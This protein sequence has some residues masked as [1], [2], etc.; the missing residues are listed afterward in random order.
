MR[1]G[2]AASPLIA[3][4]LPD[5]IV[6]LMGVPV[7]IAA[8]TMASKLLVDQPEWNIPPHLDQ[9]L[10]DEKNLT[11]ALIA[12]PFIVALY[13]L[14]SLMLLF[15]FDVAIKADPERHAIPTRLIICQGLLAALMV[16]VI[17]LTGQLYTTD[18]R[19]L[20]VA[21][22]FAILALV[23]LA[24]GCTLL[25]LLIQRHKKFAVAYL[26]AIT[27]LMFLVL[28]IV[29]SDASSAAAVAMITPFP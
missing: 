15:V 2:D 26:V 18:A 17:I 21:L 16:C 23:P 25:D 29:I 14:Y 7:A 10:R 1:E 6:G 4:A 22:C 28:G 5:L 3:D 11:I 24:S 20:A 27:V 9:I 8:Q 13:L 12:L 19:P